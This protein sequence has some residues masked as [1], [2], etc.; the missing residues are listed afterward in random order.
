MLSTMTFG[1]FDGSRSFPQAHKEWQ[2]KGLTSGV[3]FVPFLR[4]D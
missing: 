4:T 2:T 3:P 1:R